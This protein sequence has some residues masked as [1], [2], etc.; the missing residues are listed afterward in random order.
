MVYIWPF[1]RSVSL[2][3]TNWWAS[4]CMSSFCRTYTCNTYVHY[5]HK[6]V[7]V[8]K[9]SEKHFASWDPR[10]YHS[11]LQLPVLMSMF[12]SR[13]ERKSSGVRDMLYVAPIPPEV[14][15]IIYI[16][17]YIIYY[18][19][20]LY[21]SIGTR[22]YCARSAFNRCRSTKRYLQEQYFVIVSGSE[23]WKRFWNQLNNSKMVTDRPCVWEEHMGEPD[24]SAPLIPQTRG[25]GVHLSNFSKPVG[26]WRKC[27]SNTF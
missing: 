11:Q 12:S 23:M 16:I 3:P 1:L 7:V 5:H 22:S 17:L 15:Y 10:H 13:F 19:S 21:Y 2:R 27:Q 14:K 4:S 26:G 8:A 9:S 18:T 20:I 24:P 6:T 25:R